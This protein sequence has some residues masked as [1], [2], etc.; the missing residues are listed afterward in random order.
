V[1]DVARLL[2][3]S[4]KAVESLLSRGRATLRST[5]SGTDTGGGR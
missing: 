1:R 4:E 5:Y 3:R 2:R